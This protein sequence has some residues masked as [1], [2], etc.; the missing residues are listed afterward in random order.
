MEKVFVRVRLSSPSLFVPR[1]SSMLSRVF[2]SSSPGPRV[3]L[4]PGPSSTCFFVLCFS[5]HSLIRPLLTLS[6]LSVVLRFP[7]CS[8]FFFPFPLVLS[9]LRLTPPRLSSRTAFLLFFRVSGIGSVNPTRHACLCMQRNSVCAS[10]SQFR[11]PSR[12]LL[13]LFSPGI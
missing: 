13:S 8:F 1:L 3:L 4:F 12:R 7:V 5:F 11:L 6:P 10:P 9:S 2:G